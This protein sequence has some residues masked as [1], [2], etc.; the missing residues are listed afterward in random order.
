MK[1]EKPILAALQHPTDQTFQFAIRQRTGILLDA[2]IRYRGV[3]QRTY[4][5][6]EFI[7]ERLDEVGEAGAKPGDADG[8]NGF[9]PGVL[10]IRGHRENFF[11]KHLRS[12]VSA[13]RREFRA[14]ITA[15]NAATDNRRGQSGP[16]DARNKRRLLIFKWRDSGKRR[17]QHYARV[18]ADT[19]DQGFIL[20]DH[21]QPTNRPTNTTAPSSRH[22][23]HVG[24]ES[25]IGF[26]RYAFLQLPPQ[27]RN[28]FF[29][30]A[31][32]LLKV[33]QEDANH[34]I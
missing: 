8:L 5:A 14:T 10:I 4:F 34:G 29:C 16:R 27:H 11:E 3:Q 25:F 32:E 13:M 28:G 17:T 22:L 2:R 1:P 18:Q 21:A 12:E 19:L 9:M 30:R 26:E 15:Q 33:L 6:M 24:D 7:L 31:R 23:P 20:P